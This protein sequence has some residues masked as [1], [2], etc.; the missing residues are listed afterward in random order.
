[1]FLLLKALMISF[2]Q[3]GFFALGGGN[4]MIT[5]IQHECVTNRNWLSLN[6]FSTITGITFLFPG[7]TGIKLAGL[8]GHKVAGFPG[9]IVSILALNL[10][11]LLM[12][13]VFTSF[14]LAHQE[15]AIV[16]KLLIAVQYGAVALLAG[17][18]YALSKS[19]IEFHF[20]YKAIILSLI[21][22]VSI[23]FLNFSPF[24]CMIVFTI[25]CTIIL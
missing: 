19:L 12:A 11:G 15:K 18:I 17:T 5:L 16:Q 10:P 6:E 21:F 20:N 23:A 14:I 22:F 8:I 4:S 24:I 3:I 9:L 2:G 25:I 1:M 13:L 7:L